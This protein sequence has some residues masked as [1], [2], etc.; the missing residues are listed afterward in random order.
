MSLT[1]S[2]QIECP[3]WLHHGAISN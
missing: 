3:K 2:N 1:A